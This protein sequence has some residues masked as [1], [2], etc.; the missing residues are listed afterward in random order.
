MVDID[1]NALFW[2]MT[3]SGTMK[4]IIEEPQ[5]VKLGKVKKVQPHSPCFILTESGDLFEYD[6]AKQVVL[7]QIEQGLKIVD[8]MYGRGEILFQTEDRVYEYL[9]SLTYGFER[10]KYIVETAFLNFYDYSSHYDFTHKTIHTSSEGSLV[11]KEV[12]VNPRYSGQPNEDFLIIQEKNV[13]EKKY[14]NSFQYNKELGRGGFGSVVE[15]S[16]RINGEVFAIKRVGTGSDLNKLFREIRIMSELKKD[17]VVQYFDSWIEG[18]V[19]SRDVTKSL[20]IRMERCSQNL[21]AV[22]ISMYYTLEECHKVFDFF[23]SCELLRELTESVQYLH[24]LNIIHRD[25]KP[26]NVLISDGSDGR[27]IKLC[28]FGLATIHGNPSGLKND[29]DISQIRS[30]THTTKIGTDA[31]MAPEV[32]DGHNYN[33][34]SDIYSL[35]LITT[36][37]FRFEQ[38]SLSELTRLNRIKSSEKRTD[39]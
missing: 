38:F 30:S 24:S 14:E 20:Y 29:H 35:A 6:L 34:K 16:D 7:K 1:G 15:V 18:D 12:E 10:K 9:V 33:L 37:I 21:K 2:G 13:F 11:T 3:N 23:I 19:I 4:T 22:L 26:E 27:F 28:D 39:L 31:Y 36:E 5:Y 8:V 17:F 32:R 25:L